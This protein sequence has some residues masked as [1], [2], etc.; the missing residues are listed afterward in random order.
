MPPISAALLVLLL[1]TAA[2]C[3]AAAPS[4]SPAPPANA[5][6]ALADPNLVGEL[7]VAVTSGVTIRNVY[8]VRSQDY[9]HVLFLSGDLEGE[10]LEGPDDI[11][12][13]A[14]DLASG[15][16]TFYEVNDLAGENGGWIPGSNKGYSMNS[17]G[18]PEALECAS[19]AIPS[20]SPAA[21]A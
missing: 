6:C 20:T 15:S 11:G 21:S 4:D 1:L 16:D 12:V 8:Y 3:R 17:D 5:R 18:A 7:G 14:V 2:A 13:W 19:A 10:G 9:D